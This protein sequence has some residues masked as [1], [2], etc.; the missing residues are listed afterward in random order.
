MK[1]KITKIQNLF[2][3][4]IAIIVAT[5]VVFTPV[6]NASTSLDDNNTAFENIINTI[7]HGTIGNTVESIK[8]HFDSGNITLVIS[9]EQQLRALAEYV[10]TGND[11]SGKIIKLG[12]DINVNSNEDWVP[13]GND[14]NSFRGKFDGNYHM[15]SGIKFNRNNKLNSELSNVGLFGYVE[16]AYIKNVKIENS[17]LSIPY[18][19][20]QDILGSS[21]DIKIQLENGNIKLSNET[22]SKLGTIVGYNN[23]GIIENCAIKN[24]EIYGLKDVAGI[25]GYNNNGRV[26]NCIVENCNVK[27][28]ENVGGIVGSN[29]NGIIEKC[30]N[31]A[32]ILALKTVGGIVGYCEGNEDLKSL[33]KYSINMGK[34]NSLV[35]YVGGIAGICMLTDIEACDNNENVE[36]CINDEELQALKSYIAITSGES[37][38]TINQTDVG[39]IVGSITGVK[40]ND[41]EIL[42]I[43][44]SC[45]NYAKVVGANNVGGLVGNL[46][47]IYNAYIFNKSIK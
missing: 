45:I 41:N 42:S 1:S 23:E 6:I 11:C 34:I 36:I 17:I 40:K 37:N 12:N 29:Y 24:V 13:I 26:S 16:N 15:I 35:G 14:E 2:M 22:Y 9:N 30:V 27:A 5:M 28:I 10:N 3:K 21:L 18:N 32:S 31:K 43:V 46:N 44:N 38:I 20:N 25:V 47:R 33:I 39:G 8:K 19:L 7:V 4:G